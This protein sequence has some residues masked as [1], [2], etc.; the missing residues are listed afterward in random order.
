MSRLLQL[1]FQV[2]LQLTEVQLFLPPMMMRFVKV[3]VAESYAIGSTNIPNHNLF[4]TFDYPR[5]KS[6]FNET[7]KR[8]GVRRM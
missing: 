1:Q 2:H 5:H 7:V 3:E 4:G 6:D 8:S